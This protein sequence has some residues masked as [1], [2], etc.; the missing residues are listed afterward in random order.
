MNINAPFP[1]PYK[2]KE[3]IIITLLFSA[4]IFIFLIIFQPFGISKIIFYKFFYVFGF[5][6]ITFLVVGGSLFL[7]PYLLKKY[8]SP[9]EW[10]V[11]KMFSFIVFQLIMI[12]FFNW[13]YTVTI[14]KEVIIEQ[15]T[16]IEFVF[17]TLA[18][19]IF[20]I[21]LFILLIER[22]LTGKNEIIAKKMTDAIIKN[23]SEKESIK[24]QELITLEYENSILTFD[25]HELICIKSDGN[26]AE[27]Y[28]LKNNT[29]TKTLVRS[30]LT[31]I[32]Q[33]LESFE[34]I[35]KC[36]RSFIVNFQQVSKISGNARNYNLHF[37]HLDFSIPVSRNFSRD[38]INNI[39]K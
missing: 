16:L 1:F 34:E 31:R 14:G 4:F 27:V 17:I 32:M 37:R 21:V 6:L 19:G 2:A 24:K 35:Q 3:K 18:V 36:H 29:H 20:P 33:Q 15:K 12:S 11:K 5:S 26:Y 10:T 30:S 23:K 39:K 38:F 25:L 7:L 28:T 22:F 8:F 13:I 9:Q